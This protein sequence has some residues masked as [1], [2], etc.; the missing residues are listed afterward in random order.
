M[1]SQ[2]EVLLWIEQQI[3]KSLDFD[4][5]YG[6]QCVDL[7]EFLLQF[8]G[9]PAFYGNA[10]DF[11]ESGYTGNG[12]F[13]RS[14][15]P[16]RGAIGVMKPNAGNGGMGHIFLVHDVL[17]GA[18]RSA[19]QNWF[20]SGTNGS[21]AA[22]VTHPLDNNIYGFLNP[23]FNGGTP[24]EIVNDGDVNFLSQ[25]TGVK[26]VDIHNMGAVGKT[27]KQAITLICTHQIYKDHGL[28][29]VITMLTTDRDKNLYPYIDNVSAQLGVPSDS[30][31][32]P[33]VT[34]AIN[35]LKASGTPAEYNKAGVED[36]ISKNLS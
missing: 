8:L 23:N 13:T 12:A 35:K 27:W 22:W 1:K 11:W 34:D 32:L 17:N 2:A 14:A 33:A 4:G 24:M 10:K 26:E 28:P 25:I 19:D 7:I 6:A 30:K 5:K 9:I 29:A 36:Y 21:P 20:N 18:V 31:N 16:V 3:G 15:T